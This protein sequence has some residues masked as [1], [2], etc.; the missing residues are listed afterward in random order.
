MR[1]FQKLVRAL[2][3]GLPYFQ[4]ESYARTFVYQCSI[5]C[6]PLPLICASS[7]SLHSSGKNTKARNSSRQRASKSVVPRYGGSVEYFRDTVFN[8]PT[9]AEAHKVAALDGLNKL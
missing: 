3:L 2:D 1:G 4:R 5:F 9:L 6:Q 7:D 8:Y